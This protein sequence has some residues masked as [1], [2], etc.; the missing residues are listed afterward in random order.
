MI[1]DEGL[2]DHAAQGGAD[3]VRF[4][5]AQGSKERSTVVGHVFD[6]VGGRRKVRASEEGHDVGHS[7]ELGGQPTVAVVVPDDE[8]AALAEP[9]DKAVRP[10]RELGTKPHDEEQR[11][12]RGIPLGDVLDLNPVGF[13]LWHG[14]SL[15][16]VQSTAVLP[17]AGHLV[18]PSVGDDDPTTAASRCRARRRRGPSSKPTMADRT[19][20]V[21]AT[22]S[23]NATTSKVQ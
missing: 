16:A 23:G 22:K 21:H 4:G 9:V 19:A 5:D 15:L 6:P 12:I 1:D 20:A 11:R 7:I 8:E 14:C 2:R 18:T 17:G 3:H 10:R 13:G